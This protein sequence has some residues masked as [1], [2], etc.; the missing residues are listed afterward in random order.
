MPTSSA[1]LAAAALQAVETGAAAVHFHVRDARGIES[2][3]GADVARAVIALRTAIPGIPVGVSTGAWIVPHTE[4]RQ[5]LVAQW[6]TYP[7]YA[8]INFDEPGAELLAA[9][10]LK[11][12]VG[13]EAGVANTMAVGRL[14]TS[15]LAA[16]CL[17]ILVEPQ[18][19][20]LDAALAL[21]GEI[22][23]VLDAADIALPR[24][25]HGI[26]RTAWPMLAEAARRGYDT[27]IGFEDTLTLPNGS[28]AASNAV[29]VA[30]ARR[31]F[32]G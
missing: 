6:K 24:L 15:G 32:D 7:D 30:E 12:D 1:E 14:A 8:S 13:I 17:R 21:V 5:Q 16:R 20:D 2:L 27:R 25:L 18:A 9:L 4:K 19:Q 28:M 31:I 11:R 22:E 3:A 23:A 10:L 29:L 26:D